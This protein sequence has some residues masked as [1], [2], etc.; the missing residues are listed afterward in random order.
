MTNEGE[1]TPDYN[2]YVTS[3]ASAKNGD[4]KGMCDLGFFYYAGYFVKQSDREAAKWYK[5]S[6][7]K[8]YAEAQNN[9][10]SMYEEGKGVLKSIPEAIRWYTKAADQDNTDACFNLA[11]LYL[12]QPAE[13]HMLAHKYMVKAA[14]TGDPEAQNLLGIMYDEGDGVEQSF[15]KAVE[16]FT[17]AAEQGHI[18]AQ[19]NL[20]EKYEKGEGVEKSLETAAEWYGAAAEQDDEDA[21]LKYEEIMTL[22]EGDG[23]EE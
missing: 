11:V 22:L 15:E 17:K 1:Y 6:A 23:Q 3:M 7:E 19:F 14:E 18:D 9:L 10:A 12:S 21:V 8:G 4:P 2:D 20:A 5:M 16:W 13:K